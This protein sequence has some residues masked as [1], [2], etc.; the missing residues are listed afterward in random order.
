MVTGEDA[1]ELVLKKLL[2]FEYGLNN[3]GQEID[4]QELREI[5]NKILEEYKN[6]KDA[7]IVSQIINEAINQFEDQRKERKWFKYDKK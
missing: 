6:R 1:I 3:E 4:V 5:T 2:E 7:E